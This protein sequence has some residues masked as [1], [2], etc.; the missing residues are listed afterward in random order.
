MDIQSL[1]QYFTD[2]SQDI[3]I[4]DGRQ[5]T[6]I[7]VPEQAFHSFCTKVKS[8][9][10][11]KFDYLMSLT[12]VDWNDHFLIVCHLTSTT[13]RHSIVVK[14]K[15]DR[16]NPIVDSLFDVWRTAEFH[17]R[18]VYDL[19]GIKFRNHPD[20]RRLFLEDEYGFPLRKDFTDENRMIIR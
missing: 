4:T 15:A 17:E 11:L 18:E 13:F 9:E 3:T 2:L 19:F 10:S 6:E 16:Q 7:L 12:A 5:Y 14:T 20:L 8:D 1:K